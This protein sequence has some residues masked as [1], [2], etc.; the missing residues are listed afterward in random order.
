[1][2]LAVFEPDQPGNLGGLMR[3]CACF[4][5]ELRIVGSLGFPMGDRALRR[6]A[7]DYGQNLRCERQP[8]W[9]AF[10]KGRKQS[11]LPAPILLTTKSDHSLY[12]YQFN[13]RDCLLLGSESRGVPQEI[14]DASRVRLSIPIV[15]QTRSLNLVT[16]G[17]IALSEALRQT[18]S[19]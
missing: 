13:D 6:A 9:S 12:D 8:L 3:L 5:V 10:L 4:N 2:Q 14:H 19:L 17:A 16:A 18:K 1:M 7:M 15:D 11:K